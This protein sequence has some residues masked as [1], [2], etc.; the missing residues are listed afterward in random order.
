M[1]K[2]NMTADADNFED[3]RFSYNINTIDTDYFPTTFELHWH[4][5]IEIAALPSDAKIEHLPVLR[6]NQTSYELHPGDVL[7]MW[8]GDLHEILE[9]S[10]KQLIGVQFPSTLF[11]IL[12]DFSPYLNLFR[13]FHLIQQ[14][15]TPELAQSIQIYL[16]HMLVAEKNDNHFRGVEILIHLCEMFMEFGTHIHN[17]ILEDDFSLTNIS[18]S[19]LEKINLACRYIAENC[20]QPLNLNTISAYAG[21]STCYFSRLFKQVT[22]YNFAEYLTLQRVKQA[23]ILLSDSSLPITEISFLSGFRSISTF[24]RSFH[25]IRGCSPSEYR[26]YYLSK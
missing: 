11:H 9:N 1:K 6:I 3:L 23:E 25:Q 7:F 10:D 4:K 15:E 5:Y 18:R 17:T 26:C 8:P 13:T 22:K 16:S 19:S 20:N 14:E 24:N 2:K 12:P 21:F